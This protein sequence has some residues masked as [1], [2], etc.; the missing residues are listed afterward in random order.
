MTGGPAEPT[1]DGGSGT[2]GGKC[3]NCAGPIKRCGDGAK[4]WVHTVTSLSGCSL[5]PGMAPIAEPVD[6]EFPATW[7]GGH[8]LIVEF[9]DEEF[10]ARCLC[11]EPFGYCSPADSLDRFQEPWER[12]VMSRSRP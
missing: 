9:G 3:R 5:L 4:G 12:H 7:A 10:I 6:T 8:A 2:G 11:G 1:L